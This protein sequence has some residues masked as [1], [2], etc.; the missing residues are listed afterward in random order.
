MTT[1]TLANLWD[2]S[3]TPAGS[4]KGAQVDSLANLWDTTAPS[5]KKEAVSLT[6][7]AERS[8]SNV[9]AGM[10]AFTQLSTGASRL[11]I[12][13]MTKSIAAFVDNTIGG[14]IPFGAKQ[15]SYLFGRTIG[16]SPEKAEQISNRLAE[17]TSKPFG[18]AFGI[19]DDPAYKGEATGKLFEF[20][21]ENISK[22]SKY[23]GEKTGLPASDI[24]WMANM[25][26]PKAIE[27][28][29]PIVKAG[30]EKVVEA[31]GKVKAELDA[32]KAQLEGKTAGGQLKQQ[33]EQKVTPEQVVTP[34]SDVLTAYRGS[35]LKN[36]EESTMAPGLTF[37]STDKKAASQYGDVVKEWQ[38]RNDVK[39]LD[40]DVNNPD[41]RRLAFVTSDIKDLHSMGIRKPEDFLKNKDAFE[42][43]VTNSYSDN[44]IGMFPGKNAKA[45]VESFGYEGV[46]IGRDDFWVVGKP[47]DY[48][49]KPEGKSEAVAPESTPVVT[50]MNEQFQAK[51]PVVAKVV[52]ET[53]AQGGEVNPQAVALHEKALS[54]PVP[55]EL[56]K[57]QA[58]QDP[59]IISRE[60][61]ERGIK[62]QFAQ[63]FNEQNKGLQDNAT[64]IKQQT[65]P[66]VKTTDYVGDSQVLIDL[67]GD[68]AK[69]NETKIGDA[70]K[71]LKD[72]SGGKFPMDGQTAAKQVLDQ[73]KEADR[74]DY[75]PDIYK[76]K[77]EAYAGGTK[78]MNFNLFENLRSDLAADMRK[79]DRAGDGVTKNVLSQVRDSLET[80][81]LKGEAQSLKGYADNARAAFKAE[82]DLEASNPLYAKVKDGAADT[83]NFIP[84]N[85]I[86]SKNKD[87]AK[88]M[89]LI[90]DNPQARQNLAS[91]TLDWI[92]R[93][94][95]D[96]S[97]NIS[98]AKFN[99]HIEALRLN[100]RLEPIFGEQAAS[101]MNLVEVGRAI[102]ARPRGAF[103]N[104][105]NTVPAGSSL[106]KENAP[107]I[108]ESIPYV[109]RAINVGKDILE[110]RRTAKEVS[111]SLEPG[112]GIKA[113]QSGKN[114][115]KDFGIKP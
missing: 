99:K 8:P 24:E 32:A 108:I 103:V 77:L 75:L 63:R 68:F 43:V 18:K 95:T 2:A 106:I 101:L 67:V 41:A 78:Q 83:K 45:F 97:G 94:S 54:L 12:K 42:E 4:P 14:I 92:I 16:D 49:K 86:R 7:G 19:S 90:A 34:E 89:E 85:I 28:G 1:D 47:S 88:T 21:G 105:S 50:Q 111:E 5:T 40:L 102:E 37:L 113:E 59:V 39:L 23:V 110:K 71:A 13:D 29:A 38:L 115:P 98:T 56:T 57:G 51:Q 79:A 58:L 17:I 33:F 15:V 80:M 114:K 27:K 70:Y 60:R 36:M 52:E 46:K 84:E 82:K 76:K 53:K 6:Q 72:Q 73:L 87:F 10:K 69:A 91:G 44:A 35:S 64:M 11:P 9:E 55:I 30:T 107:A 104:E 22:G 74:L 100:K 81:E 61:N 65:A 66:D 48:V 96:S 109:G 26:L 62:E 31:G 3:P 25:V 112:A 93:D 20:I